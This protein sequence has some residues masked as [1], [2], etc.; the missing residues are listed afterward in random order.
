MRRGTCGRSW[1][2]EGCATE[3]TGGAHRGELIAALNSAVRHQQPAR[4]AV[5]ILRDTVR[6]FA[7]T[8]SQAPGSTPISRW[9]FQASYPTYPNWVTLGPGNVIV[10]GLQPK[11]FARF[12][13]RP[14]RPD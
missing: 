2:S 4:I 9:Q 3:L 10:V 6:V 7:L 5:A 13:I 1:S 12:I 14:L 8:K 11:P